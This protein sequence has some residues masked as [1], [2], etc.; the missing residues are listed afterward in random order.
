MFWPDTL[1]YFYVNQTALN[2]S[3]LKEEE[4]I[5]STLA[6]FNPNF[7]EDAFRKRSAP[8]VLGKEK[9][10]VYEFD[11]VNRN[12]KQFSL[13]AFLQYI[14]PDNEKPRFIS[15][16]R[17]ITKRLEVEREMRQFKTTL[18]LTENEVYMFWPD[19][20]KLFYV[21]QAAKNKFGW[22]NDEF[23][24]MTPLD[25]R[26]KIEESE[27]RDMLKP[28]ILGK[29]QS[30]TFETVHQTHDG[31]MIPVEINLQY[32][33]P[34]DEKPRF[35]A[36]V[37][38]ITERQKVDKA[39]SEFVSTVSHELRTPLTAIKGILNLIEIGAYDESP[40]ELHSMVK[41][42]IANSDQLVMLINDILDVEKFE[43]GM[44]NF[45]MEATDITIL[46]EEALETYKSYGDEYGVTF[47][48]S[49][50]DGPLFVNGDKSRL[51]QVLANL[52]S[53]A[54]KFSE[55]GGRVEVFATRRDEGICVTV[56]DYG[57]GIP[58]E[59]QATIFDKFTQADSSD[60]RRQ[61]GTGLGLSIVKMIIEAHDGRLG[62]TTE[63]GKGTVLSFYLKE[64]LVEDKSFGNTSD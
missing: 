34:V 12:G 44:M 22:K 14:T 56:K 28:L 3:D 20:L 58:K 16:A 7:D 48:C 59:A 13:E 62:F 41:I 25:V 61:G 23:L 49:S 40:E 19:T 31:E 53:N 39:K 1:E 50:T 35:V 52:L 57:C 2:M 6:Q 11:Y 8:L 17:N 29:Q 64:S 42:A 36:I 18:D 60:H 54:A 24:N 10:T 63:L 21:N 30:L 32:L 51:M 38:D 9:S 27:Y 33:K 45:Q 26:L 37:Q 55:R 43:A 47:T 15:I 4:F 5:G 46:I